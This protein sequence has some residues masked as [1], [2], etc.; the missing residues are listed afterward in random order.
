M[1]VKETVIFVDGMTCQSC[2]SHIESTLRQKPGVMLVKVSLEQKFSFIGYDPLLTSPASLAA[3]VDDIGFEVSLGDCETLS[4]TWV[5]VN[6]MTCQSCV[7]HIEGM[8]RDV[9]GV[10]SVSVSL[11][12]S[13]ATVLYDCMQTSASGLC[14]VINDIGFEAY[15]LPDM[16]VN[17]SS[18]NNPAE[19]KLLKQTSGD[20]FTKL[21]AARKNAGQQ[22]CEISVEGMTCGS[23][24]KNIEST[25]SSVSGIISVSVSLD[26]KKADVVFNPAE[27]SP[28]IVA[29]K[30]DDIGFVAAVLV[31]ISDTDNNSG[32]MAATGHGQPGRKGKPD[33][34]QCS[35]NSSDQ[36]MAMLN[37]KGMH[38]QSCIRKI[39]GHL[40][41][42]VGVVS[43]KVTLENELCHVVYDPSCISAET[44]CHAVEDAGDFKA[45]LSGMFV[46]SQY[47]IIAITVVIQG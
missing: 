20:E 32:I 35:T 15:L 25:M 33:N 12:D 18:R 36:T 44:L 19:V 11:N 34:V 6:G 13:L 17:D 27:I 23:C 24:V 29:E 16:T 4:A 1:T 28:E 45:S 8:V 3:V 38:C 37:I 22:T 30:I 43:V 42:M 39:E 47:G 26:Q 10:R 31:D 9:I 40:K 21:A 41:N 5:N 46:F 7:Q 2:V 14:S